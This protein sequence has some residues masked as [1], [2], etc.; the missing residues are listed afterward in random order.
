MKTTIIEDIDAA[1]QRRS[2]W[3][4]RW[5]SGIECTQDTF[6]IIKLSD[7]QLMRRRTTKATP[8]PM[9]FGLPLTINDKLSEAFVIID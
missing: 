3:I 7:S 2:E 9:L 4:G 6:D 1:I 5:V 8:P